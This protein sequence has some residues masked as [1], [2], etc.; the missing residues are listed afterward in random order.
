MVNQDERNF[1]LLA[2]LLS[3][4]A[5]ILA[6]LVIW[7]LK[8]DESR[9]VDYHAKESLNFQ[10]SLLIY[11]F[12]CFVLAFVLIGILLAIVL[13]V[14]AIVC[15]LIATIKAANGEYYRYPFAIRLLK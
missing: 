2:H 10:I 5:P 9:F 1:A 4:F 14:F 6:P 15:T 8:K 7:V 13:A 12:V 3:F 11:G